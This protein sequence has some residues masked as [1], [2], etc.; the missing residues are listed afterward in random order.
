[1][2]EDSLYV[3]FFIFKQNEERGEEVSVPPRGIEDPC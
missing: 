1:M 3:L 2:E